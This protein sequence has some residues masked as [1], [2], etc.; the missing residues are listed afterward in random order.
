MEDGTAPESQTFQRSGV[1]DAKPLAR[2]GVPRHANNFLADNH[3]AISSHRPV[4]LYWYISSHLFPSQFFFRATQIGSAGGCQHPPCL[5]T[6]WVL[7][8]NLTLRYLMDVNMALGNPEMYELV[9]SET[10][11]FGQLR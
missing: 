1:V 9:P 11:G 6:R 4:W 7:D 2:V 8:A 10:M 3:V 5:P